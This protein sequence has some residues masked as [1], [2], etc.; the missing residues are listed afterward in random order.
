MAQEKIQEIKDLDGGAHIDKEGV[1]VHIGEQAKHGGLQL[2]SLDP[3]ATCFRAFSPP[4]KRSKGNAKIPDGRCSK[5]GMAALNRLLFATAFTT[6]FTATSSHSSARDLRTGRNSLFLM[7]A[8]P[9][10]GCLQTNL[11]ISG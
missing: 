4:T 9:P 11:K 10:G 2:D 1:A 7:R 6:G 8:L 5:V 3:D